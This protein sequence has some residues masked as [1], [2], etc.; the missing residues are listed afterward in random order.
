M[1]GV[2]DGKVTSDCHSAAELDFLALLDQGD[3]TM[4]HI[5]GSEEATPSEMLRRMSSATAQEPDDAFCEVFTDLTDF[6][7]ETSDEPIGAV[8]GGRTRKRTA[9]EALL[10]A[11]E[12]SVPTPTSPVVDHSDYTRKPSK[13]ARTST[14]TSESD[15]ES[16]CTVSSS[17]SGRTAAEKYIDRRVKNNV[18]SKR[19]RETRKQKF[20]GMEEEAA[21][22]EEKNRELEAKVA[23]LEAM[24]KSMKAMLV[25]RLARS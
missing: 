25:T 23:E 16:T 14:V 13:R 9:T 7:L 24:A 10:T 2:T 5:P 22:L 18:A 1:S 11:A 8:V 20:V 4:V 6:L 19:S 15:A 21:R 12:S 17:T 3:R